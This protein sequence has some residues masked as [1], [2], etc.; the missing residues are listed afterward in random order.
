MRIDCHVHMVG[1]GTGGTGCWYRPKGFTKIGEPFL[2]KAVGLTTHDLHGPDFDRL[3]VGKLLEFIRTSSLDRA[4]LLAHELPHLEDG[5]PLPERSS[6][7]VPNDCVLTLA[8]EHPEFL[9]GVSIHPARKDAMEELEKCLAGSASALKCLPNVQ[10]IDWNDRRYTGFLERM[11]EAGLPLL[12]HTGSERTMPV[13]DHTL[14]SPR[15]LTRALEIG[16]TCIAAH[17]G[18]GMMLLDP[19]YFDVFAEMLARYPNLYG[20]NSALAGLSFRLRPSALGAM[21]SGLMDGRILHGS[22]LPVPPSGLLPWVFGM[23][24]WEDFMDSRA[25]ANP[26]ERDAV[27]KEMM[28]FSDLS[29]TRATSVLRGVT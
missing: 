25:V 9:A 3:Y 19:D 8:K 29:F 1:T 2:V 24:R 13:M 27:L 28:G 6:L 10:G 22:D 17:A 15:V 20:D 4:L 14:A 11:A 23:I 7:Y 12:A 16:V 21:I 26:L 5:T 18:T